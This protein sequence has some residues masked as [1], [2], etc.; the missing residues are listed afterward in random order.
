[1][2][3]L[4][5]TVLILL[6][7]AL[8][9]SHSVASKPNLLLVIDGG[10]TCRDIECYAAQAHTRAITQLAYDWQV[11]QCLMPLEGH[12]LARNTL[13]LRNQDSTARFGKW[14]CYGTGVCI[15]N[16]LVEFFENRCRGR[17]CA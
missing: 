8:R 13:V 17:Q 4:I 15:G 1:M 10:G 12:V 9:V 14:M 2:A 5:A 7:L 16:N 6:P 3:W 11:G